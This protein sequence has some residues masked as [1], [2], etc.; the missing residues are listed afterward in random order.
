MHPDV[1][2]HRT[3]RQTLAVAV[4]QAV[5]GHHLDLVA[6]LRQMMAGDVQ[7]HLFHAA[8]GRME[9]A[10]HMH[11]FHCVLTMAG[12]GVAMPIAHGA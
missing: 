4:E 9:L 2:V 10:H 8:D 5:Q 7:R 6:A 1:V 3:A 12:V 11:D